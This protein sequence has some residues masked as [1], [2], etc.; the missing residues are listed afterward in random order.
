MHSVR[1]GLQEKYQKEFSCANDYVVG[2]WPYCDA[3]YN[4]FLTSCV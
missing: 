1:T 4:I 2:K 3:A